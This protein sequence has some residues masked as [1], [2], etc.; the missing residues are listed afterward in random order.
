MLTCDRGADRAVST[1][2]ANADGCCCR[3]T[4]QRHCA[5]AGAASAGWRARAVRRRIALCSGVRGVQAPATWHCQSCASGRRARA[6]RLT[7]VVRSSCD[8]DHALPTASRPRS[9]RRSSRGA[10]LDVEVPRRPRWRWRP[11]HHGP[12]P[13][14]SGWASPTHPRLGRPHPAGPGPPR[15][16]G[17]PGPGRQGC[18]PRSGRGATPGPAAPPTPAGPAPATLAGTPGAPLTCARQIRVHASYR[19]PFRFE[20]E[21]CS[22]TVHVTVRDSIKRELMYTPLCHVDSP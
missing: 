21:P 18:H 7:R 8:E 22:W 5:V 16:G 2:A 6:G 20:E 14:T 19:K 4:F 10:R 3:A 15:W 12:A 11:A 9:Q 13:P 1:H 17:T